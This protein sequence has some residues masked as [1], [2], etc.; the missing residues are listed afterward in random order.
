MWSLLW[1]QYTFFDASRQIKVWDC[2]KS[3]LLALRA[4]L[5]LDGDIFRRRRRHT[6]ET[7]QLPHQTL[8]RGQI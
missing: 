3:L 7:P 6:F 2:V 4:K 8:L 5:Y 1:W